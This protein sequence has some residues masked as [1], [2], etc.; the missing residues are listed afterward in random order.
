MSEYSTNNYIFMSEHSTGI[1]TFMSEYLSFIH[2]FMSEYLLIPYTSM[3]KSSFYS[4]QVRA[5]LR[6]S[7]F[8]LYHLQNNQERPGA[9][10]IGTKKGLL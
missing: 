8:F 6:V 5:C 2:T 1:Y 3:R 10:E 4:L 7:S 9:P